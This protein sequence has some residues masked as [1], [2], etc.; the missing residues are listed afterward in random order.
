MPI[1]PA[2]G[3][4]LIGGGADLLGGT[5]SALAVSSANKRNV[6][7]QREQRAWEERMSN[8]AWQR[9][10]EDM[11]AAGMNPMLAFSQGGA[12]T[13]GG[14]AATVDPIDFGKGVTSA[15]TKAAQALTL[16]QQVAQ[17]RNIEANTIKTLEEANIAR[18]T[19]GNTAK[20]QHYEME[21]TRKQIEKVI[22]EFQLTDAQRKQVL[23]MLPLATAGSRVD[24]QLK[25][26][27][28]P[29]A[30]A[31]ASLWETLEGAGA[32]AK[33]AGGFIGTTRG[34]IIDIIKLI[35]GGK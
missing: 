21:L 14:S 13:P 3:A 28:V 18:I 35:K 34:A 24:T 19:S 6:K 4:A 7:L 17:T 26:L 30:R 2:L 20:R 32:A 9:G 15:G 1:N 16:Q 31:E 33:G 10:M 12:S 29:S 27:Q 5:L 23:E 11:K 25:E 8:T 22:S